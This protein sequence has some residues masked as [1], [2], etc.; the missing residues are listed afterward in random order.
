MRV[1]N[2]VVQVYANPSIGERCVV[3]LLD[4]YLSKLPRM[5]FEK[6]TFYLIPKPAPVLKPD[7]PWHECVPRGRT[8]LRTMVRDMCAEAG[9]TEK[10]NH[11]LRAT[12]ASQRFLLVS[13]R[14]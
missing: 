1:T 11:S 4:L 7:G 10:T 9:I 2:K 14:S 6:S 3:Y 5:T 13:L 12:S 8:K